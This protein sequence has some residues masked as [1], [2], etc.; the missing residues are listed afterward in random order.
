MTTMQM[1]A[2]KEVQKS[3]VMSGR[4]IEVAALTTTA[5]KLIDCQKHWQEE[6]HF[7]KLDEALRLNQRL[8]TIFQAEMLRAD[9]PL[10]EDIKNNILSLSLFID[11]QILDILTEPVP[12]KLDNLINININIA[13]GLRNIGN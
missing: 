5:Q 7:Q 12:E 11:R 13:A 6:G 10:P 4:E 9:N 2:Y 8:W 3:T 1:Q